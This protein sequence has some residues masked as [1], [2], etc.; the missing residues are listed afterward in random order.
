M[1]ASDVRRRSIAKIQEILPD[2]VVEV[3]DD[4]TGNLRLEVDYDQLR[5]TLSD[6]VVEGLQERY[7][8]DWPGKRDALALA[9][10]LTTKTLCP[11]PDKSFHYDKTRNLFIEG[12][13]LDALKILQDIY[14]EQVKLIYIDPPYNTGKDF[15]Y[16]DRFTSEQIIHEMASG[17]RTEEGDRLVSNPDG[18]GR[19]HSNWLSMMYPRLR[20]AKN[21]LTRDG[22]IFV[23]CDET[24]QPR[25]R[26]MMDEIFG[27]S[28][29]IAD[30][31]WAAGRK[32]DSRFVSISHEYIVCYARNT[33]Y[34][35]EHKVI[36]RQRKKG[37]DE[38]YSEHDR[39]KR[40]HGSDY[41]AMTQDL[42]KWFS[43]L[44]DNHPSRDHSH[45]CHVDAYGVY[46]PS[47]ISWPGGG[48]PKYQVLHPK[49][50]KPV[51]IPS[52]GWMTSDPKRMQEWI[53]EDRIHFGQDENSVPCIKRYLKNKELQVPYSVFYQDGRAAS[54][55]L[56][57]LFEGNLFDFPKDEL[58]LQEI[59]EMTTGREDIVL[60]FFAGSSTTAHSVMLQNAADGGNRKFIMV[61]LDESIKNKPDALSAG[62]ET[63]SQVSR[64][65]IRRAG[66]KVINGECHPNWN[67]DIGF[68][69]F[70]ICTSNMK[71]FYYLPYEVNQS[72][73][74]EMVDN[75]KDG[76]TSEDLL[77]QVLIDQGMDL[78]LP[79]HTEIVYGKTVFFVNENDLIACFDQGIT[80]KLVKELASRTPQR[81]VFRDK[82][83]DSDAIKINTQQIFRQLSPSTDVSS[84]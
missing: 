82:G 28:N 3:R 24:E 40:R 63:I 44:K 41:D 80:E 39:L 42:K 23:S 59:I 20:L 4:T 75:V 7:R 14:P 5:Q 49:T 27:Q 50:Q 12:D 58:I 48:G 15:I 34:L 61:Q 19:F 81:A 51:K 56:R 55:R 62:F 52:R 16:Q 79:I 10:K 33:Q 71:D 11:L 73:L 18:N 38:I 26:M 2:C 68:R 53:S 22:A 65:R 77:F 72:L 57:A 64:E 69:V 6:H 35:G 36:W 83:F 37:L 66:K 9:N 1:I 70:K 32:N 13:N 45:Y 60:D 78:T 76:R 17:E 21:L 84:I 47:D 54:K 25:L 30:M 43:D 67:R 8:I 29:F 74:L 46:F 31:V